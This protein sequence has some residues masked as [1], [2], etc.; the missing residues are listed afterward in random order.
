M[1]P[2]YDTEGAAKLLHCSISTI[3]E[4]LRTGDLPGEKFGDGWIL[5]GQALIERVNE[6][7]KAKAEEKRLKRAMPPLAPAI[8]QRR[9]AP[10]GFALGR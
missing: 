8:K 7:A 2:I 9:R 5:P 1:D 4:R 6:I 3:E 10:G